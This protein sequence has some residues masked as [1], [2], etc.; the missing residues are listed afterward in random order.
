MGAA[1]LSCEVGS[2]AV[3]ARSACDAAVQRSPRFA[4]DDEME[5]FSAFFTR[6]DKM[7][8]FSAFFVGED[9]MDGRSMV[10]L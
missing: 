10:V 9:E 8:R 3:T 6:D 5:G 7:E 1:W 2:V 4:R